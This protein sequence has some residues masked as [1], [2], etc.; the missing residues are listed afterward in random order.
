MILVL[1]TAKQHSLW[2]RASAR[3]FT[4]DLYVGQLTLSTLSRKLNISCYT[5][6]PKQHYS[7]FRNLPSLFNGIEQRA[8]KLVFVS[9]TAFSVSHQ[10]HNTVGFVFPTWF[11]KNLDLTFNFCALEAET[12]RKSMPNNWYYFLLFHLEVVINSYIIFQRDSWSLIVHSVWA[13]EI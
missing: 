5:S 7:F 2:R 11:N 1:L 9:Q 8:Q 4:F 3:N 13:L 10:L 6:P 12:S